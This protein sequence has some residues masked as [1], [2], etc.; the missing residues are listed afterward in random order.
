MAKVKKLVAFI[1]NGYSGNK[2]KDTWQIAKIFP[3]KAV[4]YAPSIFLNVNWLKVIE[5]LFAKT[6]EQNTGTCPPI[7]KMKG[8]TLNKI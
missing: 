3:W 6:G 1:L 4:R 7:L 2:V 8:L 5:R